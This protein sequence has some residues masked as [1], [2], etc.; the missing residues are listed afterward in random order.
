M[1]PQRQRR[2]I[3]ALMLSW[4]SKTTKSIEGAVWVRVNDR[5]Y[6]YQGGFTTEALWAGGTN[7]E[8]RA[9]HLALSLTNAVRVQYPT[10]RD[11]LN[12]TAYVQCV[13]ILWPW[14]SL[15]AATLVVSV[16]L[17]VVTMVWTLRSE[18]NV[19]KESPLVY[20]FCGA[21]EG[22]MREIDEVGWFD[23][24]GGTDGVVRQSVALRK[25]EQGRWVFELATGPET[26]RKV[27]HFHE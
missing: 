22:A 20:L 1:A 27:E 15:P 3:S 25:G 10:S 21:D 19:W 2:I 6:D 18:V 7:Y 5:G 23:E 17:L 13:K 24:I 9:V 14:I 8:A 4:G 16:I 12:G 11:E 26:T